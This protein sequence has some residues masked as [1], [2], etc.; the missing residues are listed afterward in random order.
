MQ[1]NISILTSD[2]LGEWVAFCIQQYPNK[3]KSDFRTWFE[4][5]SL[6]A[7]QRIVNIQSEE[8]M[9]ASARSMLRWSWIQ[10]RRTR[11]C[12]L[13]V[14][15]TLE[16]T[17]R[18]GLLDAYLD[19]LYHYMQERGLQLGI[20]CGSLASE[21]TYKG[22]T[23][24]P[25]LRRL[26]NTQTLFVPGFEG[27]IS[28]PDVDDLPYLRGLYDLF[29]SQ[30]DF[31]LCLDQPEYWH[32][33]FAYRFDGLYK[34]TCDNKIAA[35]AQVSASDGTLF[36]HEAGCV[37]D[38]EDALRFL[39]SE[40]AH[41]NECHTVNL[42][43]PLIQNLSGETVTDSA[44]L[45]SLREAVAGFSNQDELIAEVRD[46]IVQWTSDRFEVEMGK[47]R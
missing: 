30:F 4:R 17:P 21:G 41:E 7:S 13:E 46:N 15:A 44:I 14:I 32:E 9:L 20:V 28:Q 6:F 43:Q 25:L 35:Y 37:P 18:E 12:V 39:F 29:S 38:N 11:V 47:D 23:G 19:Y 42:P 45:I 2:T 1:K 3:A 34:L 8:K 26:V 40:L 16:E 22:F 10:G 31:S 27:I 33:R 5:Q 24:I 36:I